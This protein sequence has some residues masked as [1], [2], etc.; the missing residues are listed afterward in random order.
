MHLFYEA[1]HTPVDTDEVRWHAARAFVARHAV[2]RGENGDGLLLAELGAERGHATITA[3]RSR[4]RVRISCAWDGG[5]PPL[6]TVDPRSR[7]LP[8]LFRPLAHVAGLDV[9]GSNGRTI[10]LAGDLALAGDLDDASRAV[11]DVASAGRRLRDALTE[12]GLCEEFGWF[13]ELDLDGASVVLRRRLAGEPPWSFVVEAGRVAGT[14]APE[15]V[16]SALGPCA[17]RVVADE[18]VVSFAWP[19]TP[20]DHVVAR[21]LAALDRVAR[22]TGP[23]R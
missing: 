16:V 12:R 4:A 3:D 13:V 14:C 1:V 23:Y 21:A 19:W 8:P 22:P 9:V 17:A 2:L 18:G 15:H 20:G 10:E 6:P 5:G 7:S 11:S